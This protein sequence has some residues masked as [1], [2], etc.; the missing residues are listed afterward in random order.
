M[1]RPRE[2]TIADTNLNVKRLHKGLTPRHFMLEANI[3]GLKSPKQHK[4]LLEYLQ[5]DDALQA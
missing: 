5:M 2:A 4:K 1:K 3:P